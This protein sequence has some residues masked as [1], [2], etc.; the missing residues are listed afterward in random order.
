MS[1]RTFWKLKKMNQAE[2]YAEVIE[3]WEQYPLKTQK[4]G[5]LKIN[6]N[7]TQ[8]N[9]LFTN[10]FAKTPSIDSVEFK[11]VKLPSEKEKAEGWWIQGNMNQKYARFFQTQLCYL[12]G[13]LWEKLKPVKHE[14]ITI[15]YKVKERQNYFFVH[16]SKDDSLY[17]KLYFEINRP[18]TRKENIKELLEQIEAKDSWLVLKAKMLFKE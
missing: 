2:N 7:E 11:T 5:V 18:D 4:I 1:K 12:P 10:P 3:N 6:Y 16:P 15:G 14:G 17:H 9:V 13:H 8:V